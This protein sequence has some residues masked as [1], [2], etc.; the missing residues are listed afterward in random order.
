MV[1]LIKTCRPTMYMLHNLNFVLSALYS[2]E[3]ISFFISC[4][5]ISYERGDLRTSYLRVSESY[6]AYRPIVHKLINVG[7]SVI[8]KIGLQ[9]YGIPEKLALNRTA[10][11]HGMR[12]AA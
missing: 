10:S 3:N 4:I 5:L 12:E 9:S 6:Y 1:S 11:K 2:A 8:C 7:L